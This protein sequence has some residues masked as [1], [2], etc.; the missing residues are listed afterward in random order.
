[1]NDAPAR[2]AK[3]VRQ[4]RWKR[5]WFAISALTGEGCPALTKAIAKELRAESSNEPARRR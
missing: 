5:P 3:V 4:L 2:A 1:M